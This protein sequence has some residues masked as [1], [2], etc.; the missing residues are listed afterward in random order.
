ML[1]FCFHVV[2]FV[3]MW[4]QII[5]HLY[6][7]KQW[8]LEAVS[9]FYNYGYC[10]LFLCSVN[11]L[12]W[13]GLSRCFCFVHTWNLLCSSHYGPLKRFM[14]ISCPGCPYIPCP[15][16]C[17]LSPTSFSKN[18]VLRHYSFKTTLKFNMANV[19][20]FLWHGPV[21]FNAQIS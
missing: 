7:H 19:F 21:F 11:L 15:P 18:H 16:S 10:Q 8:Q 17:W 12:Y 20:Q 1:S 4:S 14:Q 9:E 3:S 5:L 6:G 2:N 13:L